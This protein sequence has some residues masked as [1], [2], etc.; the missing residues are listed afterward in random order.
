MDNAEIKFE[1][2]ILKK[3]EVIATLQLNQ[4]KTL[5]AVNAKM[6]EEF[7]PSKNS[8]RVTEWEQQHNRII[9]AILPKQGAAPHFICVR[10]NTTTNKWH[11]IDSM[12]SHQNSYNDLTA[13]LNTERLNNKAMHFIG[14]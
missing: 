10:K 11:C 4:P 12:K 8:V 5:N 9:I 3:E 7:I 1:T 6:S 2:I 14:T 13:L